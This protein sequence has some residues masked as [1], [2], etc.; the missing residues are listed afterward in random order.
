MAA[1]DWYPYDKYCELISWKYLVAPPGPA[2]NVANGG[3][4]FNV[5]YDE[6]AYNAYRRG[7]FD[8]A[9]D[10]K[11]CIIRKN[12]LK[13]YTTFAPSDMPSVQQFV[14]HLSIRLVRAIAR[15]KQDMERESSFLTAAR[16][17][18]RV[19]PDVTGV[20]RAPTLQTLFGEQTIELAPGGVI[21]VPLIPLGPTEPA[22]RPADEPHRVTSGSAP[23][24]MYEMRSWRGYTYRALR[25]D[26]QEQMVLESS[27]L[28]FV[29]AAEVDIGVVVPVKLIGWAE[30]G[31]INQ[32]VAHWYRSEMAKGNAVIMGERLLDAVPHVIE[33]TTDD[34]EGY[35]LATRD[36]SVASSVTQLD[37]KAMVMNEPALGWVEP[38]AEDLAS[39]E[40][41]GKPDST[42]LYVAAAAAVLTVGGLAYYVGTRT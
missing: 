16:T 34:V 35:M 13:R 26:L 15:A 27:L 1:W 2:A 6:G 40:E 14:A 39:R 19:S 10:F 29:G 42:V 23:P 5:K 18:V 36:I 17:R 8:E 30:M 28:K 21:P 20:T 7:G 4:T 9:E 33:P 38:S 12:I 31:N 11:L 41:A 3:S 22:P 37:A 24:F 25:S 32:E